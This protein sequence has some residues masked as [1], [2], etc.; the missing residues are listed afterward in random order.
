MAKKFEI[1]DLTAWVEQDTSVHIKAI[2]KYGDPVELSEVD[3]N[4]LIEFLQDFLLSQQ[5]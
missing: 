4:R 3:V 1:S 5:E 2:T